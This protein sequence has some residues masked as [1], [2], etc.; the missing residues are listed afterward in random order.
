LGASDT[1]VLGSVFDDEVV[2]EIEASSLD[3]VIAAVPLSGTVAAAD[4]V[5]ETNGCA[6]WM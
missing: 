3:A 1:P 2:V 4:D 5:A 6:F